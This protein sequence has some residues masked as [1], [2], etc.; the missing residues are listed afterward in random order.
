M[1]VMGTGVHT[2]FYWQVNTEKV[3]EEVGYFR[4]HNQSMGGEGGEEV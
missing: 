2:E 1:E 3:T 4:K